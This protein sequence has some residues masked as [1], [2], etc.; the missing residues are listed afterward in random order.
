MQTFDFVVIGGG[1][2]GFAGARTAA[3]LGL[4]TAII[5]GGREVGGLCILRGCMPSKTM[6]ESANR[7]RVLKNAKEFGLR[8]ENIQVHPKEV[9]ARKHSLIENFADY[10][11]QQLESGPFEFIRGKARFVDSH[12]VEVVDIETEKVIEKL[13]SKTFLIA[14]GSHANCPPIVGLEEAGSVTSDEILEWDHYPQSLIV[15]GAGAIGLEAAYFLSGL[16]V[17]VTL[18]QRSPHIL[19]AADTDVADA[20]QTALEHQGVRIICNTHIEKVERLPDGTRKVEFL[21]KD[22]S[23]KETLEAEQILCAL[24]RHP[25]TLQLQLGNADVDLTATCAVAVGPDQR[26]VSQPHI[27]AAGD[28]AGP[29][30]IV[31]IAIQQAE[32]AAR[33]AALYIKE[34]KES[35]ASRHHSAAETT[36]YRLRLYV[37]FTE[38]QVA[39]VGK[40]EKELQKEGT[41]YRVA[42]YPFDD[43]GKSMIL[44]ETD[45][46]VKL[47]ASHD[48]KRTLL[49]AAV[50]GPQAAELIHEIVVAMAFHGSAKDIAQI[51]HYHPTLSEIWTYPAEELASD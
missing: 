14:T 42:K 29:Y 45:G 38:P 10:R 12:T 34:L 47:I 13:S 51:P 23:T 18:L 27:F 48:A 30:E 50:V 49:G 5:E 1:S 28:A 9:L 46:F 25:A 2:A 24:G 37:L 26:S 40:T 39:F 33:N 35:K 31:H 8:A 22:T 3:S 20:L 16:G 19:S 6:I 36:D 43:H 32:V 17:E 44:G 15:L 11:R 21:Q 4:K 41:P 7:F